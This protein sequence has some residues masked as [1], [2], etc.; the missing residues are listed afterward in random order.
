M[1]NF[2]CSTSRTFFKTP[3]IIGYRILDSFAFLPT[4]LSNLSA[5]LSEERRKNSQKLRHLH[6]SHL[7]RI[8]GVFNQDLYNLCQKKLA[9]PF[10][11]A[12]GREEMEQ[13]KTLPPQSHFISTLSGQAVKDEDFNNVRKLWNILQFEN[14]YQLYEYYCTLGNKSNIF[15]N[16]LYLY[17]LD[18][19]LLGE[20]LNEF[21]DQCFKNYRLYPDS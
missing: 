21:R 2:L 7:V 6:A 20:A 13:I 5:T 14:L 3:C 17:F 4:S 11:Y 18:C 9:F 10:E 19:F 1:I 16:T 8:N 15:R 12:C